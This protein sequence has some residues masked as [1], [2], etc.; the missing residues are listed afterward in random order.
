MARFV[1][2]L[3]MLAQLDPLFVEYE[4]AQPVGYVVFWLEQLDFTLHSRSKI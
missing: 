2:V 3:K 4:A 1:C